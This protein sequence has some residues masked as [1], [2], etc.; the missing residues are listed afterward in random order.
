M[1]TG[2]DFARLAPWLNASGPFIGGEFRESAEARPVL[3]P[4]DLTTLGDVGL[5][6]MADCR[7]AVTAA[8]EAA[9]TWRRVAPRE[10][11]EILRRA[12][13]L[14]RSEAEQISMLI[15]LENGKSLR[16]ARAE[17]AYAAE[18]FRWFSEQS[19]QVSGESRQ[20]PSGD[21]RI[22]VGFEPVGV[23]LLVTPWNYP[24]AMASRKLAPALAAGCT[25]VLKPALETPL[26]ALYLVE[27]LARAGVPDGVVN[28]VCVERSGPVVADMM[29]M[30]PVRLVTF[31]GS[32][33]V[34]RLLLSGA[35]ERVLRTSMELGG[36]A[37]FLVLPGADVEQSVEQYMVAKFRNGGAACTAANRAYVHSSVLPTFLSLLASRIRAMTVAAGIE[38]PDLG[39]CVNVKEAQKLQGLVARAIEGGATALATSSCPTSGAFVPA[40]L[41]AGVQHGSEVAQ[42]E[43][44]G[45]VASVIE[46]DDVDHAVEMANDSEMGLVAYVSGPT[47]RARAVA[48]DLEAGMIGVNRGLVSDPSAPFGGVK[49]SGLGREGGF[50]G[51]YEFLEPKYLAE[52]AVSA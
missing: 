27:L 44:F 41:L 19:V 14:M 35:S 36:N 4:S 8:S 42:T 17:V 22:T 49:Q 24:A 40:T 47:A 39:A 26:T 2:D 21:K 29:A 28:C 10:R 15:S 33:E 48:W 9:G 11:A 13:E 23:A 37:P 25:V 34:G 32:T 18:F 1:V 46:Y 52:E 38:D 12:F 5:A 43:I 20:S 6:T 30:Q 16:D 50:H 3:D 45:P 51:I 31:T 7:D